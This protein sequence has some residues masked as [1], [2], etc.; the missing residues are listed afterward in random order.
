MAHSEATDQ[1]EACESGPTSPPF[2]FPFRHVADSIF[3]GVE[4]ILVLAWLSSDPQVW[5]IAGRWSSLPR[6]A[7]QNVELEE[8]CLTAGIDAGSFFG[9]VVTTAFELGMDV[10]GFIGAALQMSVQ[11]PD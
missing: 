9:S 4:T 2:G 8:P 6:K 10:S 3:G 7:K 5:A 11:A 1:M